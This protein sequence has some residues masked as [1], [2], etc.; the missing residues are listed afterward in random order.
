MFKGQ[1]IEYKYCV[2]VGVQLQVKCHLMAKSRHMCGRGQLHKLM[3]EPGIRLR[4]NSW[5]LVGSHL[6]LDYLN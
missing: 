6:P 2:G 1:G 5:Q 4:L 3:T